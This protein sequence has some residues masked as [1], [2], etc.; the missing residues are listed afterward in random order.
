QSPQ[1]FANS[2]TVPVIR[3]QFRPQLVRSSCGTGKLESGACKT[4]AR[5]HS[6]FF[7]A[8]AHLAGPGPTG[9]SWDRGPC[10]GTLCF[11]LSDRRKCAFRAG[12]F[13]MHV[14]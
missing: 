8:P 3:T 1:P 12:G 11:V 7:V 10:P 2:V 13:S 4:A 6:P 5:F 14:Q 9:V